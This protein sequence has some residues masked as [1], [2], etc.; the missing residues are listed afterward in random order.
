M[1]ASVWNDSRNAGPGTG[2]RGVPG[3]LHGRVREAIPPIY[4]GGIF[5]LYTRCRLLN[6][7]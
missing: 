2:D 5:L 3:L 6:G 4:K 1:T 7:Y